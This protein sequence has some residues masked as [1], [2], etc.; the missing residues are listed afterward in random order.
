LSVLKQIRPLEPR[1]IDAAANAMHKGARHAYAYFGWN[2]SVAHMREFICEKREIW[3]S[4]WVA[5]IN[6]F[7]Q[8]FMALDDHFVDQLF[9]TPDWHGHGLG[10]LL[11]N[12]A[13]TIYPSYLELDCAQQNFRACRFYEHHGFVAMKHGIHEKAGIGEITYRWHGG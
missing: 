8:G 7:L 10:R 4:L 11:I 9:I 3:A 6:G 13:K 5:E 1:D 2:R 12:K